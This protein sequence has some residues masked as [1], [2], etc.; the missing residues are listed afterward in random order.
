MKRGYGVSLYVSVL[1][2]VCAMA[3]VQGAAAPAPELSPADSWAFNPPQD[4]FTADAVLDL[5]Y[6]N[7]KVAGAS[8]FVRLSADG[9]SFVRGDGQPIRF[10]SVVTRVDYDV[11]KMTPE[12]LDQMYSFLAKRGVNMVRLFLMLPIEKEGSAIT[13]VDQKQIDA[14]WRAVSIG[15]KHGVYALICPY[16]AAFKVPQ[17]WGL[18]GAAGANSTALLFFNPKLQAAYK[19]WVRKLYAPANPYTGIALKDDPSVAIIQVQ[20][21]DGL[22]WW[23]TQSVPEGQ[24]RVLGKQ[25]GDW[26]I[27]KHKSLD[28]AKVAWEG[29]GQ[30][31]D[32]FAAGVVSMVSPKAVIWELTQ[33]ATGGKA[34]R[35]RDEAEFLTRLQH[36][37]YAGMRDFYQKELGCKQLTNASNWRTGDQVRLEDLERWSNTACDVA[38]LNR[39]SGGVHTGQNSGYRIDPGHFLIS[40]SVT[41]NPLQVPV[42]VRQPAGRPFM[43]TENAWVNPNLYQSEGPMMVAAYMGLTGVDTVCWFDIDKSTW[44]LDPRRTFWPVGPGDTGY[45]L[46]KW[47]GCIPEQV[48]MFPANALMHRMGYIKQGEPAVYEVRSFE[49]L[50]QRKPPVI[51]E[52]ESFD[53]IRDTQDLRG[54]TGANVSAVSR[55]AFLVGPV[56]V[57]YAGEPAQ[58]KVMDLSPYIDGKAQVVRANTG[59][60]ELRYGVGL[61]MLK[62][63]KAQGVA[64]FLKA[65]GGRFDLGDV[66]IESANDYAAIEA[67]AMDDKP[68]KESKKVLVQVGTV[69]RLTGWTTEPATI[70]YNDKPTPAEK[71][72]FTGKPPWL[73][74][75]TDATITLSNAGL[76]K[77]TLLTEDG[78]AK[79]AVAVQAAGGKL[80][81][82]LPANTMYLV[83]E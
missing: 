21:E 40:R 48:G 22:F 34:K 10:W 41:L 30:P 72:L 8:G 15:K 71:I 39:Y 5:S 79:G 45:A 65:A 64:G 32:D 29:F 33:N 6:L 55:L 60:M 78:Y 83:L 49:D 74:K 56:Q 63:P 82:K 27:A 19:E 17:S 36:D 59:E 13:D 58:T 46:S 4:K 20:N 57:S 67:V 76:T 43:L 18:E 42:A 70:Q 77:A 75:N 9:N 11:M 25:F 26:L 24:L 69:C 53:P 80:T 14:A 44:D 28:A 68:L 47:S 61:F 66:S 31:G 2:A 35:L 38:A 16:W 50:W 37:F 52:S 62:A 54:A 3:T 51:A 7:E 23:S 1:L 81:V 73:V 12:Q